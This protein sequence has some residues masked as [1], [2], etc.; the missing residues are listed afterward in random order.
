MIQTANEMEDDDNDKEEDIYSECLSTRELIQR[1]MEVYCSKQKVNPLEQ[2]I[3]EDSGMVVDPSL[4]E[5]TQAEEM[6]AVVGVF[7]TNTKA[8][9]KN[10]TAQATQILFARINSK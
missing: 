5:Q 8:D 4:I 7:L 3:L 6:A 1:T 2:F 9:Q 10:R